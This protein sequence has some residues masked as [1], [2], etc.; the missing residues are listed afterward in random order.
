MTFIFFIKTNI[1]RLLVQSSLFAVEVTVSEQLLELDKT[2]YSSPTFC[3]IL[4]EL[5]QMH[6]KSTKIT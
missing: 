4:K 5:Q 6:L 2:I 1:K 3:N